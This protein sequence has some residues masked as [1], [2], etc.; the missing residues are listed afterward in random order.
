M[1]ESFNFFLLNFPG[2]GQPPAPAER[3]QQEPQPL[4]LHLRGPARLPRP[5]QRAPDD[6]GRLPRHPRP[7]QQLRPDQALP[8]LGLPLRQAHH[9][10][11]QGRGQVRNDTVVF[12]KGPFIEF[13]GSWFT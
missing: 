13:L 10:A 3:D 7:H 9:P 2:P 5:R 12:F 11:L 4:L 8:Q 6:G 1:T